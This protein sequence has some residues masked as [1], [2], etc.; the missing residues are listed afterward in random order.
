[1]NSGSFYDAILD[2]ILDTC[3]NRCLN[4]HVFASGLVLSPVLS[5][6]SPVLGYSPNIPH[7][8]ILIYFLDS[9]LCVFLPFYHYPNAVSKS[10]KISE[11]AH[12]F[13]VWY[14][15]PLSS[16]V[17]LLKRCFLPSHV[18]MFCRIN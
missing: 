4:I 15:F 2:P 17:H 1:M 18:L 10:F 7:I 5:P 16:N 13:Y 14:F 9:I 12:N 11:M 6:V 3:F 8:V